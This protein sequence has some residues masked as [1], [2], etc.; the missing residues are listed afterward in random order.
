MLPGESVLA[1][2]IQLRAWGCGDDPSHEIL[3][4]EEPGRAVAGLV[5]RWGAWLLVSAQAVISGSWDRSP[6]G[7]QLRVR[8]A[9]DAPSSPSAP[10]ARSGSFEME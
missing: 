2:V 10:P 6:V 1:G 7:L 8:A 4:G 3:K 5:G 9:W